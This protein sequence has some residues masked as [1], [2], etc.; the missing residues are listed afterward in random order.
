[1]ANQGN[2]ISTN[3]MSAKQLVI[4]NNSPLQF[5][6]N[7]KT[8]KTFFIC[9]GTRGYVSPAVSKIKGTCNLDD[10]QY[11]ECSTDNGASFVPCLMV[12]GN[13]ANNVQRTLGEDL[14]Y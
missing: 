4:K 8:G 10:L 12:V 7:P 1:M 13:S 3:R 6:T 2:M 5:V 14:L 11:A 9:G